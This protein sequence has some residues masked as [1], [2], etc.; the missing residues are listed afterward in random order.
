[1]ADIREKDTAVAAR[2][3]GM[4]AGRVVGLVIGLA[5]LGLVGGAV[6]LLASPGLRKR[7]IATT[8][9]TVALAID[10]QPQ[11]AQVFVDDQ[12][13]GTTPTTARLSPGPHRVRILR[14]GFKPWHQLVR[15]DQVRQLSPKLQKESLATLVVESDPQGANVFLDGERRGVTP[16]ELPNIEAGTHTVTVSKEPIYSG[17]RRRVELS[18][19]QRRRVT[20]KLKSSLEAIYRDRIKKNPKQLSNY[21]ELLHLYVLREETEKA[22]GVVAEAEKALGDA[23]ASEAELRQFFDELNG[24]FK[25]PTAVADKTAR[26]KLLDVVVL[27]FE[28]LATSA[29]SSYSTYQPLVAL[30][31]RYDRFSDIYKVCEKTAEDPGRRGLLHYY[32]AHAFL[33]WGE[34]K[35]AITLL[36]RAVEL[37]PTHFYSRLYLGS[38]YQRAE[39]YDE[40]MQHYREAE[41]LAPKMSAYYQGLLQTYI[42]K[43]F[44]ARGDVQEAIARYKKALAVKAPSTYSTTWRLQYAEFLAENGRKA[45][46]IEQYR[47]VERRA[48]SYK[49]RYAAK[50]ALRRLTDH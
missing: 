32:V 4:R 38:A 9:P 37:R 17:V 21:T 45:E 3:V 25:G 47:E 18:A 39:K 6:V 2:P 12:P 8:R 22:V 30:L 35:P 29:P 27:L 49:V 11:G 16:I 10:S 7:L 42:A 46:A 36:E 40:A 43:L 24:L 14:R 31:N 15:T 5:F 19:G 1:M 34:P 44:A 13:A 26:S 23:E 41:K 28:R 48:S 33:N 20:V 50:R